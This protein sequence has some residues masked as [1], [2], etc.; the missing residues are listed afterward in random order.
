MIEKVKKFYENGITTIVDVITAEGDGFFLTITVEQ[1]DV[2][3]TQHGMHF[4]NEES[5]KKFVEF[6]EENFSTF[7]CCMVSYGTIVL[8][9]SFLNEAVKFIENETDYK[10]E[11]RG[12]EIY[13]LKTTETP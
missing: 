11:L 2:E 5:A 1:G 10:L 6:V 9:E 13:N 7:E 4:L 3:L 12:Q 8:L